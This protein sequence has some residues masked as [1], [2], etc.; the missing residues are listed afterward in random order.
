MWF[1]RIAKEQENSCVR[2]LVSLGSENGV[3]GANVTASKAPSVTSGKPTS[4]CI[5]RYTIFFTHS[6]HVTIHQWPRD[7][8]TL[9][10]H[11]ELHYWFRGCVMIY[12]P[13]TDFARKTLARTSNR[14]PI[15]NKNYT[16]FCTT[17]IYVHSTVNVHY[18][19]WGFSWLSPVPLG[20]FWKSI[21]L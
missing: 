3:C 4:Q 8:T 20:V 12:C 11:T 6:S 13:K 5:N 17:Y 16:A 9:D 7:I 19:D 2:Y 15:G 18:P 21:L 14:R 10:K 1:S